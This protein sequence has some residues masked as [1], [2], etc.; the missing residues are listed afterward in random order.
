MLPAADD[1]VLD[2]PDSNELAWSY[3][4]CTVEDIESSMSFVAV[5]TP[6]QHF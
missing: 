3:P 4:S 6:V 5:R 2:T 1:R